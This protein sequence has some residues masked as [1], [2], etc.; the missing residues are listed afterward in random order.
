MSSQPPEDPA[1]AVET[2]IETEIKA[3]ELAVPKNN[4]TLAEP[5]PNPQEA[6]ASAPDSV[7]PPT[8]TKDTATAAGLTKKEFEIM[9]GILQRLTNYRDEECV[10][11]ILAPFIDFTNWHF[12]EV[13]IFPVASSVL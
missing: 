1:P 6:P 4:P 2:K 8:P 5:T 10:L 7:P 11:Q 12:A 3:E 13:V 9:N